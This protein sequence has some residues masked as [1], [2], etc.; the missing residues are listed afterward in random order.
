M[1]DHSSSSPSEGAG[2]VLAVGPVQTRGSLTLSLGCNT[3]LVNLD[4]GVRA[5]RGS[6]FFF[7]FN[8]AHR[9]LA[10]MSPVPNKYAFGGQ[11]QHVP[12]GI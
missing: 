5:R 1:Q 8:P 11:T 12:F 4:A 6:L 7:S 9:Q 10:D 3:G 2:A